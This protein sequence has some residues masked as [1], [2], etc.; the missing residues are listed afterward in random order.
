MAERFKDKV[1][2]ARANRPERTT[3]DRIRP[4]LSDLDADDE[5]KAAGNPH[6]A[7]LGD[8]RSA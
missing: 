2:T 4:R 1:V 7:W 6:A 3:G 5:G 8:W